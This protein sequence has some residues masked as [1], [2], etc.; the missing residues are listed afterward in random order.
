M[1]ILHLIER[2]ARMRDALRAGLISEHIAAQRLDVE[3]EL[4]VKSIERSLE[5][6]PS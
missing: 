2:L 5:V 4:L 6:R 3:V 1:E